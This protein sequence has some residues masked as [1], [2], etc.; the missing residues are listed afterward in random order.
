MI[1]SLPLNHIATSEYN[2]FF[3]L[4]IIAPLFY[5]FKRTRLPHLQKHTLQL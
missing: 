5:E 1:R 3:L 2:P 4:R